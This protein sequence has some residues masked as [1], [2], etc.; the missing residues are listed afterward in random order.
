[1]RRDRAIEITDDRQ[2]AMNKPSNEEAMNLAFDLMVNNRCDFHG[3]WN[4][5]KMRGKHLVSPTGQQ[6]GIRRLQ[7]LLWRDEM[8]LRRAGYASRKKAE[9]ESRKNQ[10]VKVVVVPLRQVLDGQKIAAA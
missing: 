4:G 2:R 6:M 9:A 7:G 1:M 5:W 3:E 8:E 10:M